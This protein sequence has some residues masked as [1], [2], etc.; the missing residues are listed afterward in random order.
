MLIRRSHA[1]L[2]LEN[3]TLKPDSWNYATARRTSRAFCNTNLQSISKQPARCQG[4]EARV[5]VPCLLFA[6]RLAW[7]VSRLCFNKREC[8]S[9]L[10]TWVHYLLHTVRNDLHDLSSCVGVSVFQ[11]WLYTDCSVHA[12]LFAYFYLNHL[13]TE[14][15][16]F[17]LSFLINYKYTTNRFLKFR[18]PLWF[19]LK[20]NTCRFNHLEHQKCKISWEFGLYLNRTSRWFI[21][22]MVI[23]FCWT[24]E[25][26]RQDRW[27][28]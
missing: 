14:V 13:N 4:P 20:R 5:K 18:S 12:M 11:C 6:T 25:A 27:R 28:W 15:Y 2:T 7:P 22:V 10:Q 16:I 23:L 17:S 9:K 19:I 21:A 26:V 24:E 1:T 8:A 3:H